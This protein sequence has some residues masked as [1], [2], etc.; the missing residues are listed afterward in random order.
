VHDEDF[1]AALRWLIDR[2][3]IDGVVNATAGS[4]PRR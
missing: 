2:D 3:D 1:V 4:P